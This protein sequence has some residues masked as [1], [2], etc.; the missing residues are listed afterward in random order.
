MNRS[1]PLRSF[2][3]GL[4]WM[5]DSMEVMILS[6]LSPALHCAWGLSQY[7]QAFLTTVVFVGMML[8]SALWGQFS[9]RHGRRQGRRLRWKITWIIAHKAKICLIHPENYLEQTFVRTGLYN[10]TFFRPLGRPSPLNGSNQLVLGKVQL[11][12]LFFF[13]NISTF[14]KGPATVIF[15]PVLLRAAVGDRALLRLDR[16]PPLPRRHHDRLRPPVGHA[17][18]GVSPHQTGTDQAQ[19]FDEDQ[20]CIKISENSVEKSINLE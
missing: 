9:D 5:A 6:I 12:I 8:S 2:L 20:F 16:L 18:L 1:L 11:P 10:A 7:N 14:R 4:C 13:H 19:C 15:L 17:L 3:T